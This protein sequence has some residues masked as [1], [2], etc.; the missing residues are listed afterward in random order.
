MNKA[1]EIKHYLR[2]IGLTPEEIDAL[3]LEFLKENA[4]NYLLDVIEA[5]DLNE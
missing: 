3:L 5:E 2:M 1:N 4:F